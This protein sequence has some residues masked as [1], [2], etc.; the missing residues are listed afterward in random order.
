[1]HCGN[2][3]SLTIAFIDKDYTISLSHSLMLY[4]KVREFPTS[5]WPKETMGNLNFFF[6][7]LSF[8]ISPLLCLASLGTLKTSHKP[9]P[10]INWDILFY[11]CNVEN[12][13]GHIQI[14]SAYSSALIILKKKKK[15]KKKSCSSKQEGEAKSPQAVTRVSNPVSLQKPYSGQPPRSSPTQDGEDRRKSRVC[16]PDKGRWKKSLP[17][18]T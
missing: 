8:L 5:S 17:F 16:Q 11:P 15:R 6:H 9:S 2:F 12:A 3:C 10:Q 7:L 14:A 1:M 18:T 4:Q 13:R